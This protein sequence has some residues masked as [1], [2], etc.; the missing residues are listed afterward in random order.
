MTDKVIEIEIQGLEDSLKKVAAEVLKLVQHEIVKKKP[1][2]QEANP[3]P[4]PVKYPAN[5]DRPNPFATV[6]AQ[7]EECGMS[8]PVSITDLP[9]WVCPLCS[10]DPSGGED[11]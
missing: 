10:R 7:C 3:T 8:E 4:N 11:I 9:F 1:L 2:Q 5:Y 6:R